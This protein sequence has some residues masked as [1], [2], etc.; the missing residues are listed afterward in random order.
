M[1]Y[2]NHKVN[3]IRDYRGSF[4]RR[5]GRDPKVWSIVELQNLW[6][7]TLERARLRS[8]DRIKFT[9]KVIDT[10]PQND[11][12]EHMIY[13]QSDGSKT[14]S[15][16]SFRWDDRFKS[17]SVGHST[18]SFSDDKVFGRQDKIDFILT[19]DEAFELGEEYKQH[20]KLEGR[21]QY[22][23]FQVMWGMISNSLSEKLKGNC[24]Y[25]I[26]TIAVGEHKYYAVLNKDS[27]YGYGELKFEYGGVATE[28]VIK[29]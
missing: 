3:F 5:F 29:F 16:Y 12:G 15:S 10:I 13:Y 8:V 19:N 26:Y 18:V 9:Q 17:Y 22:L 28:D 25:D 20:C 27:K 1:Y 2:N 6:F 4:K 11:K 24:K 7:K 23:V 14:V 21:I